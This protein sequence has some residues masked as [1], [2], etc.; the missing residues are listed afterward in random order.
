MAN[1]SAPC[2]RWCTWQQEQQPIE[3]HALQGSACSALQDSRK[4]QFLQSQGRTASV[5]CRL[6]LSRR[7]TGACTASPAARRCHRVCLGCSS[8]A[9][10]AGASS[11]TSSTLC[12]YGGKYQQ[13]VK[14]CTG[15]RTQLQLI[16]QAQL[17]IDSPV[18]A[19][20]RLKKTGEALMCSVQAGSQ[21]VS[22]ALARKYQAYTAEVVL[23][24][25]ELRALSISSVLSIHVIGNTVS[26]PYGCSNAAMSI[27]FIEVALCC[28]QLSD[29]MK[30]YQAAPLHG[31]TAAFDPRR[32]HAAAL[33]DVTVLYSSPRSRNC[34]CSLPLSSHQ[35]PI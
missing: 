1:V 31:I 16:C 20:T 18:P 21:L 33:N 8:A 28:L 10:P 24:K 26:C 15:S 17:P 25:S 22:P 19:R 27:R 13:L 30:D 23:D 7:Y 34:P 35:C 32:S 29:M 6:R 3:R 14:A 12:K 2:S 9:T 11:F 5:P 4:Q